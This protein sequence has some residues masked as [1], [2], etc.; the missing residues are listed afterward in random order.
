M[1]AL[2]FTHDTPKYC[3]CEV[4]QIIIHAGVV[5]MNVL[6]KMEHIRSR[7][8]INMFG[9]TVFLTETEAYFALKKQNENSPN[10]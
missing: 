9:K 7:L 5:E 8:D 4:E 2:F 10:E 3:E 1:Y 6:I